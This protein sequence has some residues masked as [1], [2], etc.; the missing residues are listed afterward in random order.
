MPES[1]TSTAALLARSALSYPGATEEFPWGD[2]VAKVDR[3]VFA[4]LSSDDSLEPSVSLKLPRSA[5]YAVTLECCRPT[6]Y[7]LG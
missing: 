2:R 3:K 5:H 4:F 7:G 1:L 6:S